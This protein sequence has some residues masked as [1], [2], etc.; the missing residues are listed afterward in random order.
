M[1]IHRI[2]IL[3]VFCLIIS[4]SNLP[5]P[6]PNAANY[7]PWPDFPNVTPVVVDPRADEVPDYDI[8]SCRGTS[9]ESYIYFQIKVLGTIHPESIYI[10]LDTD[11][12][13]ATGNKSGILGEHSIGAE[14]YIRTAAGSS[15]I[16]YLYRWTGSAWE[17][18]KPLDFKRDNSSVDIATSRLDLGNPTKIN[19]LF[20]AKKG[21]DYAPDKGYATLNVPKPGGE[22][23]TET[24][25]ILTMAP[26]IFVAVG[27]LVV[28]G[29]ALILKRR[30]GSL[31]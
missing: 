29:V 11:F 17:R 28:V 22:V 20:A 3:S 5:F 10:W 6:K 24:N 26:Y 14:Y 30:N 1:K 18:S 4:I 2:L 31:F 12:N 9:D 15:P 23:T 25:L 13:S 27:V 19:I 21:T 8:I 16:T 7:L